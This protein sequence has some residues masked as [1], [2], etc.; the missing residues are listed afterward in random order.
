MTGRPLSEDDLQAFV[1]KALDGQRMA[2]VAAYLDE[3]PEVNQRVTAY[4]QQKMALR[5]ALAPIA[6]E[7]VPP[8]L[9]LARLLDMRSRITA[10]RWADSYLRPVAAAAL[11]LVI[12]GAGGWMIRD[13]AEPPKAG[14]ASL[15]QEAVESYA[16]YAPDLGRPVELKAA[17]QTQLVTWASRRLDRPVSVPD[18]S[19]SG[20]A[21][22]GGRVVATPHGP[23]VLYMFDNGHGVRLIMLMRN[24][25]IDKNTPMAGQDKGA[26]ATVSW[27][28]N[29]LG[30]SLVGPLTPA[31]LHPIADQAKQQVERIS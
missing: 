3:H 5:Q 10:R 6:D 22:L 18:L 27:S 2:E 7:P 11:M 30:Y 19:A 14:I 8:E 26:V 23:A 12:G 4:A 20:F 31:S 17:E 13:K 9:N 1:D 16:V 21:F 24:M 15:A 25:A 28:H 29:G